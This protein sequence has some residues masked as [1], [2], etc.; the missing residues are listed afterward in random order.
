MKTAKRPGPS[1]ACDS[2]APEIELLYRLV[3]EL[4]L[5]RVLEGLAKAPAAE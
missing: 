4:P 3:R 2:S 5:A 1:P